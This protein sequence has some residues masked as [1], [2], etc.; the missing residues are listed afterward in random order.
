MAVVVHDSAP[1]GTH[2][3]AIGFGNQAS[4]IGILAE[5]TDVYPEAF[6]VNDAARRCF[7]TFRNKYCLIKKIAEY[8]YLS[9][10]YWSYLIIH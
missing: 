4:V 7:N 1:Y 10:L 9:G 2:Y 6:I 3:A 8:G 5:I